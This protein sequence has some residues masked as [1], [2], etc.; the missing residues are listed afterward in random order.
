[1]LNGLYDA[2]GGRGS[3]PAVIISIAMMLFAGF[4]FTRV[5]KLLKLPNVTGYILAGIVIGPYCLDFVPSEVITGM[6]FISDLAL[7]FIAF[8][9]G[10]F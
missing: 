3:V 8:S 1:M 6:G 9:V 4:L 10:E 2:L 7:A 5:T